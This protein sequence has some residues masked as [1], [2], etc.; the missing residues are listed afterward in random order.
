MFSYITYRKINLS[1]LLL[2]LTKRYN[3]YKGSG[4]LKHLLPTI[5]I[6]CYFLP[7]AYIPALYIFQNVIFPT[8]FR[9][10]NWSFR[11]GFPSLKLLH[12]ITFSHA[13][14]MA[15][16]MFVFLFKPN[17]I[18]TFIYFLRYFQFCHHFLCPK[19]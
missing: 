16:L 2:L 13:F 19:L 5:C 4:L 17:Y 12:N 1:L 14:Y 7:I 6:L 9:S 8:C 3:L 11:H 15:S 10:S 18:D